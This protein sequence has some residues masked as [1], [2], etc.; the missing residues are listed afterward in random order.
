VKSRDDRFDLLWAILENL[1]EG[2]VAC[3]A[4]GT[5]SFFNRATREFHGLDEEALSP[6]DWGER[7][8]LYRTDGSPMMPDE[9]PL[10]RALH[11]ENI[12]DV[13]MVIAPRDREPTTV[14]CSGQSLNDASGKLIGAVVVM[15]DITQQIA[16][17]RQR[18]ALIH[19]RELNRAK[20]EFLANVAHELRNP[21]T[22]IL[23][24]T[25]MLQFKEE[26]SRTALAA[27]ESSTRMQ[28]QLIDDLSDVARIT[29][30]KLAISRDRVLIQQI[31]DNAITGA[32]PS[33]EVRAI[34][35]EL[36]SFD[37]STTLTGDRL[38][39][40]Q[41]FWNL[42]TNAIKFTPEGGRITIDVAVEDGSVRVTVCDTGR[43]ISAEFL[44]RV[45]DRY[46]QEGSITNGHPGLGIGLSIAR[47]I[48]ELHGGSI[49]ASS[50]GEN[51]GSAFEVTLPLASQ[52]ESE[53]S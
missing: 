8:S 21:L 10:A 15:R 49:S 33:A 42:L 22:S 37:E 7:Y 20:D 28:A 24:W 29:A 46:A 44:P 5:L 3:D 16:A 12:R 40:Q 14:I 25:Q 30:G 35:I 9:I 43:G 17:E 48:V 11:G 18:A 19:E 27:I 4:E 6:A 51:K 41:V 2:V 13:V 50:G 52:L 47:T 38:R 39:L 36:S 32:R 53:D 26:E 1:S 45:F 31:L 23:A 34:A